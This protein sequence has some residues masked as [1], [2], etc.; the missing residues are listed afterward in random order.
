MGY[1]QIGTMSDL[2]K[3]SCTNGIILQELQCTV[4]PVAYRAR[5]DGM[6]S[7]EIARLEQDGETLHGPCHN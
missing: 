3:N 1:P 6:L 4:V 5:H 7:R 2:R